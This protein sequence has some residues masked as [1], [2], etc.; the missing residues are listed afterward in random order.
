MSV[1]GYCQT[2]ALVGKRMGVTKTEIALVVD[3]VTMSCMI[4]LIYSRDSSDDLSM[5]ING[6]CLCRFPG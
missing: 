5:N 6:L 1:D 2:V 4:L 3:G